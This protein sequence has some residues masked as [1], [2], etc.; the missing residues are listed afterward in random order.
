LA[1]SLLDFTVIGAGFY[2]PLLPIFAKDV[3]RVGPAGFGLL[4]AAPAIGG[5]LCVGV[6]L[7]LGDVRKKGLVALWAFLGYGVCLALFALLDNFF[8]ALLLVAGLG[9]T[10]SLQAIMRQTA[11]QLLTPDHVRGRV[12]SVFTM[13]SQSVASVGAMEVG[14][15]A[16][17]LGGPGALLLGSAIGVTL[18]LRFWIALPDLRRFRTDRTN[19]AMKD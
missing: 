5:L 1:L 10:N 7:L 14:F 3:Y 19:P 12:F 8:L 2:Q 11:F 4:A 6:L 18:T 15:A 17:L 13:F 16:S 9:M